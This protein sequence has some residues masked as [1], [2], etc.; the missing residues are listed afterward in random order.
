MALIRREEAHSPVRGQTQT[1]TI[2]TVLGPEAIFEGKLV[3]KG[4]VKI[5]G[6]FKGDI[7]SEDTL[8]IGEKAEVKSQLQVGTLIV[9][10][11]FYGNVRASI[12]VELRKTGKFH[13]TI[14]SP[15]LIIEQGAKFE[16]SC[17]MG[18]ISSNE[19]KLI[20]KQSQ[21]AKKEAS[22]SL[23]MLDAEAG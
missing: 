19:E 15:S 16:G 13:G 22:R 18:Q 6:C 9:D 8:V 12:L 5:E 10:G 20:D 4:S 1:T 17:Q 3:F 21:E 14:S 2:H 11:T 7:I 23:S